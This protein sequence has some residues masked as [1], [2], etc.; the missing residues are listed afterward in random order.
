MIARLVRLRRLRCAQDSEDEAVLEPGEESRVTP[1][2]L[3]GAAK[4]SGGTHTAMV[5]DILKEKE[6]AE[7]SKIKEAEA[8][9]KKRRGGQVS[10]GLVMGFRAE[11]AFGGLGSAG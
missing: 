10:A 9:A 5:A 2:G 1:G 6:S 4:G 11:A 7:V 8:E 3:R